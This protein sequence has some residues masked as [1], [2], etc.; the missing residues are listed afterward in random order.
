MYEIK[1]TPGVSIGSKNAET[2]RNLAKEEKESEKQ[3]KEEHYQNKERMHNA[4]LSVSKEA[5]ES[6]NDNANEISN[7]LDLIKEQIANLEL[8]V[9]ELFNGDNIAESLDSNSKNI[10]GLL[11][12][13]VGNVSKIKL[14]NKELDLAPYIRSLSEILTKNTKSIKSEL[15]KL[16][17]S[18]SEIK[19]ET[20]QPIEWVFSVSAHKVGE[21]YDVK[22][23]AYF[24]DEDDG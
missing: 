15:D 22:A 12:D 11:K 20:E 16:N 7:G 2:K 23:L 17:K 8:S 18:V 5:I 19:L 3:E 1:P 14:E 24:G 13:L 9:P 21:A 4:V 6:N 10:E